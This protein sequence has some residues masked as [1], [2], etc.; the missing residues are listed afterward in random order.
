MLPVASHPPHPGP[1]TPLPASAICA[2]FVH[3]PSVEGS[4]SDLESRRAS[5]AAQLCAPGVSSFHPGNPRG[6]HR[7][8]LKGAP[9]FPGGAGSR[10]AN[11][12]SIKVDSKEDYNQSQSCFRAGV[13]GLPWPLRLSSTPVYQEKSSVS[14]EEKTGVWRVG[15]GAPARRVTQALGSGRH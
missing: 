11:L 10:P 12:P 8:G 1:F 4:C 6:R 9:G 7:T 3:L 5:S 14:Q 2:F 13:L 15:A